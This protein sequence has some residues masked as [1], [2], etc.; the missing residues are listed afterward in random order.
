VTFQ[1]H[2]FPYNMAFI[3]NSAYPP[4]ELP[5]LS[6]IM[7]ML[8]HKCIKQQLT[9]NPRN[10]SNIFSLQENTVCAPQK[11]LMRTVAR[12][13]SL[14]GWSA[15]WNI[16]APAGAF[17]IAP[18]C[19]TTRAARGGR[20][21]RAQDGPQVEKGSMEM[22]TVRRS[23][24]KQGH[25]VHASTQRPGLWCPQPTCSD[26]QKSM[27]C[28]RSHPSETGTWECSK[29][30]FVIIKAT[31]SIV[32]AAKQRLVRMCSSNIQHELAKQACK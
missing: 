9:G 23:M 4:L 27:G 26:I 2:I 25:R 12:D 10:L 3:M 31:N 17:V 18:R 13:L 20:G 7:Q 24:L 28:D 22:A 1:L 30:C 19:E 29:R 6:Q 14:G 15:G 11:D 32:K 5:C 8:K 16:A 21:I